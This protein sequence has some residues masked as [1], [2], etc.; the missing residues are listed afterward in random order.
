MR[1]ATQIRT[2]QSTSRPLYEPHQA[3]MEEMGQPRPTDNPSQQAR[4]KA[5]QLSQDRRKI[6]GQLVSKRQRPKTTRGCRLEIDST[7]RDG[8]NVAATVTATWPRS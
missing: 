1:S 5:L 6:D 3:T 2:I 8:A 4:E 7:D